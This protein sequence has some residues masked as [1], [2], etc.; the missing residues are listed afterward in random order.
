[1]LTAAHLVSIVNHN[2]VNY[3]QVCRYQLADYIVVVVT[4]DKIMYL[5]LFLLPPRPLPVPF[6]CNSI[7]GTG[8]LFA[9]I[10]RDILKATA[11]AREENERTI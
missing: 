2:F 1:M 7:Y 5:L 3:L 11:S 9:N 10:L 4:L 6:K 8:T